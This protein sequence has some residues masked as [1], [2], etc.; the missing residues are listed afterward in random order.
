M[1]GAGVRGAGSRDA[2]SWHL[3]THRCCCHAFSSRRYSNRKSYT[4][5]SAVCVFGLWKLNERCGVARLW[6]GYRV[7]RCPWASVAHLTAA[8]VRREVLCPST[9]AEASFVEWTKA[10]TAFLYFGLCF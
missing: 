9:F 1:H 7:R 6:K 5:G 10:K 2:G 3:P 8:S 4:L